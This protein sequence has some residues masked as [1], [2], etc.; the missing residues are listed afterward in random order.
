MQP[1]ETLNSNKPAKH[2][3][4]GLTILYEDRDIIVVD[5]IAGLLTMGTDCAKENTAYFRL[6]E[7][8]KKGNPRSR[9]RIFIVHRLDRDT[10]GLLVFAKHE[11]AKHFLQ[12]NWERFDKRYFAVVHGILQEKKGMISSFLAENN[13]FRVYSVSDPAKGKFAQTGYEVIKESAKYSLLEIKLFTGRKNQ[14]RVHLSEMK[15]PVV[16]DKVYGKPDETAKRM[17]LHSA[18]LKFA[19]PFTNREMAFNTEIPSFFRTLVR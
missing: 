3:P 17:A 18:S 2:Q 8:V 5:K 10:S 19:H 14:I 16:G 4:R 7:Y 13:C 6:N 1:K 11:K 12:D 9:N 15:H